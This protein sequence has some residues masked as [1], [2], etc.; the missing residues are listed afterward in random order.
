[1]S[2]PS[3][4]TSTDARITHC[5]VAGVDDWTVKEDRATKLSGYISIRFYTFCKLG[6]SWMLGKEKLTR[7]F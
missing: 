6:L 5:S 7:I 1:M 4:Y 2:M 3:K